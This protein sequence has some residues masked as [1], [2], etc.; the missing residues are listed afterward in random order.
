MA[1]LIDRLTPLKI[2]RLKEPGYYPDGLNL[3]LQVARG[4]SKSWIFRYTR[5][6]RTRE[7]GLGSLH[8]FGLAQAR[9]R[10]QAQRALLADGRDPLHERRESGL[11]QRVAAAHSITF[12]EAAARYIASHESGWRN[13]KHA[14]QWRATIATYASPVMGPLPVRAV[15][16]ELV[17]KVLEPIWTSKTETAVRLRGRMEQ[18]L[19]WAR[20][21]GYR[22]GDNPA[23]WKGRLDK[24]L[25]KPSK[26]AR[27]GHHAALP[28]QEVPRF[29]AELSRMPGLAARA[30]ELIVLTA[31]RTSEAL[32][33]RWVEFD[34]SRAIWTIPAQRMK[35]GREH[36]VPL[37]DELK[38]VFA[39]IRHEGTDS[40]FVF[41][42][43]K[44]HLS[45]MACLAVL[46]RMQRADLTVHGFRS[47]FR[48]WVS[49]STAHAGE[50]AEMALAHT[51]GNQVE[52][53]YRRGDLLD[54]RRVLMADWARYCLSA[55]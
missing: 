17:R 31:V 22:E 51:V 39:R 35:A 15:N 37:P 50:V 30:L 36:R 21:Y 33:A 13:A 7:M 11:A 27:S 52:A 1:R 55:S 2:A 49:E 23:A 28:W 24:V 18:I 26:V 54:K 19:D 32:Q 9:E 41:P 16:A 20:E 44:G 45:N 8:T 43:Q 4:G 25:P 3:Y 29:M 6:S 5:D 47:S 34:A 46:R 12:D 48:D 38:G 14:A 10:A 40:E 53:A 42:G